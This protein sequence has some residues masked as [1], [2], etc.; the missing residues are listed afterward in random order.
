MCS[1]AAIRN[2]VVVRETRFSGSG[3]GT[4]EGD[5]D[6]A[7][8]LIGAG[9]GRTG[10]LSLKLALEQLGF[11]PCYH[12][13]EVLMDPSRGS[14]WLRAVGGQSDWNTIFNGY[15]ATV[16]YPGCMFWRELIQF[17]PSAKVLLSVRNPEEWF[18]STQQTI[19]SEEQNK[20]FVKSALEEFFQKIVFHPYGDRIHDRGFMI[21]AFQRHNDEVERVV[22]RDRLLVYEVTHGWPPLCKFLGVPIPNSPFP[23]VNSREERAQIRASM[24]QSPG[25]PALDLE[26]IGKML[27]AR[28]A[29]PQRK[30]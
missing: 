18:D 29:S 22:P 3:F 30:V 12:M 9:L 7:L 1:S 11:G 16:D 10:T 8:K 17:Y 25:A 24:N 14:E 28:F 21:A 6:M 5:P 15:A 4:S 19:F 20:P 26:A 13:A 23:R 2:E 27:R